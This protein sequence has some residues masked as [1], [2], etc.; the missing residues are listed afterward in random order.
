LEV[1]SLLVHEVLLVMSL[2]LVP[3]LQ[4][5]HEYSICLIFDEFQLLVGPFFVRNLPF[6]GLFCSSDNIGV[7]F[8]VFLELL[9][10]RAVFIL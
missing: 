7:N 8:Y 4:A 1:D 5:A 2:H 10:L 6:L 9:V 3:D